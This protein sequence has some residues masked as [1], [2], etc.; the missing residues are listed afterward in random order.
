MTRSARPTFERRR[1]GCAVLCAMLLG[2]CAHAPPPAPTPGAGREGYL[3]H[4]ARADAVQLET[5]G[6]LR[7]QYRAAGMAGEPMPYENAVDSSLMFCAG[8]GPLF[9]ACAGVMIGGLAV[10]GVTETLTAELSAPGSAAADA[11]DIRQAF[12][13]NHDFASALG[14]GVAR[15]A[16]TDLAGHGARARLADD[17]GPATCLFDVDGT[18]PASA[19]ALDVV[20]LEVEFEPGYQYRLVIV[21]RA[22]ATDCGS[23]KRAP[24]RRLAY[25]GRPQQLARDAQAARALFDA[26]IDHAVVSLGADLAAHLSGRERP[27][28]R[29]F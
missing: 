13:P 5:H 3:L 14:A 9:G 22:R 2:A 10:A 18:L 24:E 6:R 26:E 15:A 11:A 21:V 17:A 19:T 4:A 20:R 29:R 1:A 16:L 28:L 7:P 23:G 25:R 12:A 27:S 8:L